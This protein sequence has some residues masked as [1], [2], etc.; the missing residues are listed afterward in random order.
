MDIRSVKDCNGKEYAKDYKLD[1][2][3][4]CLVEVN[5]ELLQVFFDYLSGFKVNN[6]LIYISF[7]L[8]DSF[9]IK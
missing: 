1:Y 9:F 7:D 2:C 3:C 8:V 4:K 6:I 5:Y